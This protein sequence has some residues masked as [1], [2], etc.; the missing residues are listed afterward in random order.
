MSGSGCPSGGET[1]GGWW[2]AR[3]E[4]TRCTDCGNLQGT[5][6]SLKTYGEFLG[7]LPQYETWCA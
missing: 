3:F 5:V 4:F 7:S 6:R 2:Q 1:A